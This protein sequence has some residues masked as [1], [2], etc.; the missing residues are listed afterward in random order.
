MGRLH[1]VIGRSSVILLVFVTAS[2]VALAP[3]A[4]TAHAVSPTTGTVTYSCC[5]AAVVD[6]KYHPGEV[7]RLPWIATDN[8]PSTEPG[9]MITLAASISGPYKKVAALKSAF[10]RHKP[11]LGRINV[12]AN[13]VRVSDVAVERRVSLIK[14]PSDAT[15][16]FY[17]LTTSTTTRSLETSGGSVILVS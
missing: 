17:E 11:R 9:E 8:V 15:A 7:I 1:K 4:P 16:G 12:K 6:A 3:F 2:T 5:T 10:A 14:I 13:Q